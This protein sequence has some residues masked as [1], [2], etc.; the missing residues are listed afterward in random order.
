MIEKLLAFKKEATEAIDKIP[1]QDERLIL[2]YYYF[3]NLSFADIGKK[4]YIDRH[5]AII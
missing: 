4:L 1:D 3:Y 2:I 5:T